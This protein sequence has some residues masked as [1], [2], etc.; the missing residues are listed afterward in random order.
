MFQVASSRRWWSQQERAEAWLQVREHQGGG[1]A[2]PGEAR[3]QQQYDT[4]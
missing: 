1:G 2:V 3:R 4:A